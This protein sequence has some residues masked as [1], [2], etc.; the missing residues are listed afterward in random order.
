MRRREHPRELLAH[1]RAQERL[2]ARRQLGP[3]GS[4]EQAAQD[5]VG[6]DGFEKDFLRPVKCGERRASRE[7]GGFLGLKRILAERRP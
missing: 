5:P 4:S 3:D 1:E 7:L 2:L 6:I